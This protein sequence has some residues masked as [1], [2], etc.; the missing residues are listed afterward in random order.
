MI[1]RLSRQNVRPEDFKGECGVC[2]NLDCL[3][4]LEP[5]W[6][7]ATFMVSDGELQTVLCCNCAPERDEQAV[8]V[9][10]VEDPPVLE[11]P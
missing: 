2:Q 3:A 5:P 6:T 4:P 7:I 8:Q 9:K 11:L 1:L 10:L